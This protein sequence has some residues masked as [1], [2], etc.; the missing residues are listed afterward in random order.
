MRP[1]GHQ[2]NPFVIA[3]PHHVVERL[4]LD[5]HGR[6]HHH[7]GDAAPR[8]CNVVAGIGRRGAR[9]RLA[10]ARARL[11][12]AFRMSAAGPRPPWICDEKR[13][14]KSRPRV[15]T[16]IGRRSPRRGAPRRLLASL[17]QGAHC[18][19]FGGSEAAKLRAWGSSYIEKEIDDREDAVNNDE[20]DDARNDG[21]R[22]GIAHSR[23]AGRRLESAQAPDARNQNREYE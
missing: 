12:S 7:V 21:P 11:S 19:P 17:P 1:T 10:G 5:N 4:L 2:G 13:R 3:P 18:S 8:A 9:A 14:S 16:R 22:C 6:R 15:P 23:C 20:Q